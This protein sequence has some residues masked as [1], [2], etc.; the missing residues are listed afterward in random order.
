MAGGPQTPPQKRGGEAKAK[1]AQKQSEEQD[2]S[3]EGKRSEGRRRPAGR[4][5]QGQGNKAKQPKAQHGTGQAGQAKARRKAAQRGHAVREINQDTAR[6]GKVGKS[7]P[8]LRSGFVP[9]PNLGKSRPYLGLAGV[10]WGR[11]QKRKSREKGAGAPLL[12]AF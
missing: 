3:K 11:L 10:R 1:R 2:P 4:T 9:G 12:M 7:G 8:G 5:Q 6:H